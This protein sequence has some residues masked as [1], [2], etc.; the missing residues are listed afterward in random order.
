MIQVKRVRGTHFYDVTY[1]S[2]PIDRRDNINDAVSEAKRMAKSYGIEYKT[3]QSITRTKV[4][5]PKVE[6]SLFKG[7]H[8]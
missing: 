2:I 1:N 7:K 6:V 8:K 4:K 5:R 3:Y